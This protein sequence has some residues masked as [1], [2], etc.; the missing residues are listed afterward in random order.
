MKAI[1]MA[2]SFAAVAGWSSMSETVGSRDPAP[3]TTEDSIPWHTDEFGWHTRVR[4]ELSSGDSVLRVT[5][6][7]HLWNLGTG[8][9]PTSWGRPITI[10]RAGCHRLKVFG[11]DGNGQWSQAFT[12]TINATAKGW[13]IGS[14]TAP[15]LYIEPTTDRVWRAKNVRGFEPAMLSLYGTTLEAG[16]PK[17]PALEVEDYVE[18][19][20]GPI[21]QECS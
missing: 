12:T 11:R 8:Q 6:P 21:P 4:V 14:D 15:I 19:D 17:I 2:A 5:T 20:L 18:V 10:M 3:L 9:L 1:V 13:F 7:K 16:Y